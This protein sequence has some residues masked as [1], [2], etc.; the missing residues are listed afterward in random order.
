MCPGC[1][2]RRCPGQ[3]K[4]PEQDLVSTRESGDTEKG[5][6]PAAGRKGQA[7]P[8][9]RRRSRVAVGT[10]RLQDRSA[11][12]AGAHNS[13]GPPGAREKEPQGCAAEDT[14]RRAGQI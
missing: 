12:L 5:L 14:Q 11:Q 7:V 4:G 10:E 1:S 3:R 13:W 6:C 9:G 2:W 8:R